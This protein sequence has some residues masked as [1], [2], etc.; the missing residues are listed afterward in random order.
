[1]SHDEMSQDSGK[2][3]KQVMANIIEALGVNKDNAHYELDTSN[4]I[5]ASVL[6]YIIVRFKNRKSNETEEL[7]M[8]LK[9]PTQIKAIRESFYV[10]SQFHNEILFYRTYVRPSDNFPRCF[11]TDERS[12]VDS[13]IALENV[14]KLE[15]SSCSQAYN[16]PLEY[17]FAAMREIGRFHGK[18]YVMKELEREKFFDIVKQIQEVRYNIHT[19]KCKFEI[20]INNTA[21]QVVEYLRRQGYEQVFCDQLEALLSHAFDRIMLK[22]V[23]PTEPLATLCHGDFTL[24]NTLFKTGSDGKPH[25]MLIDF[26]LIKYATPVIDLS[27]YLCLNCS[28]EIRR[29][30]FPEIIRVYH[31][32]LKEYLQDAGVWNAEKYSYDAILEN[33]VHGGIFGFVIASFYLAVL[34]GHITTGPEQMTTMKVEEYAGMWRKAGGDEMS[35]ILAEMLMH[36]KDLGCLKHL[37]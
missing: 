3:I 34:M 2:W 15:Y 23:Q 24:G 8:I 18:G 21:P 37:L 19:K 20:F 33:Y 36:I 11:Y 29:E 16:A 27:T 5:Y 10:D 9:R 22:I 17:T 6:Y 30:K 31:D 26:A 35:K 14:S 4:N 28:N 25:G 7:N 1:M 13:V 32:A 12:S